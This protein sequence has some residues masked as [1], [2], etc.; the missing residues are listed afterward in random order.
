MRILFY[1]SGHGFGHAT[2]MVAIMSELVSLKPSV[3]IFI[4]TRAPK[5][6]F[7]LLPPS[8]ISFSAVDTDIGVI[9]KDLFSQEVHETIRRNLNFYKLKSEIVMREKAFV[10]QNGIDLIVS[11]IPPLASIIGK[12]SSVPVVGISNFTWDFIYRQYTKEHHEVTA[13]VSEIEEI[14]SSTDLMLRLPF[15]HSM[16]CFPNVQD[17]PLVARKPLLEIKTVKH[18]LGISEKDCRPIVLIAMRMRSILSSKM[19]SQLSRDLDCIL[20]VTNEVSDQRNPDIISLGKKWNHWEFP[21][22]LRACDAVVSKLGY[23]IVSECIA[24]RTPLAYVP[25]HDFAE[26]QLLTKGIRDTLHSCMITENDFLSGKWSKYIKGL[27]TNTYQW[28]TM[29]LNGA[30]TAATKIISRLQK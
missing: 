20:I 23:G 12:V 18:R 8:S 28:P 4:R 3:H 30:T 2:R 11:D 13:L 7:G 15:H 29:D 1:I 17:I 26:Y 10:T 5:S 16:Q 27:I 25:R 19:I 22:I 21:D 14:Y 24:C 6:L 9:E